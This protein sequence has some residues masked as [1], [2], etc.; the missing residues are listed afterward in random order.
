[1]TDPLTPPLTPARF[2][3][4]AQAYGGVV[5][6]W[7][8]DVRADA[9]VLARQP[10][11]QAILAEAGRLDARLDRW[12]VAAPSSILQRRIVAAWRA[13]L[14][15]RA[16]LWWSGLGLATALAGAVAGS[17]AAAALPSDSPVS[18][19]GTA[20]GNLARQED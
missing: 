17:V 13:P 15:R 3:R 11:M 20:F 1:M 16:R 10:A 19:D 8:E 18:D 9:A 5:A 2:A 4:L 14:S 6:R 12:R 7:P